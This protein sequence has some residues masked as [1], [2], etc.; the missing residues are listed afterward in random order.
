MYARGIY[1]KMQQNIKRLSPNFTINM[2]PF[3]T[4]KCCCP[5]D[6]IYPCSQF[7]IL[8]GYNVKETFAHCLNGE[9]GSSK[10]YY[11]LRNQWYHDE[12]YET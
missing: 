2:K 4:L 7:D 10:I 5:G 9:A 12:F 3:Y 11:S 8:N 6:S 1:G